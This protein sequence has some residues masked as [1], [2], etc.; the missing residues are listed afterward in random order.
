MVSEK[1]KTRQQEIMPG[2]NGEHIQVVTTGQPIQKTSDPPSSGVQT[3]HFGDTRGH[4]KG[5]MDSSQTGLEISVEH[6]TG[7]QEIMAGGHYGELTNGSPSAKKNLQVTTVSDKANAW[8][9]S[10]ETRDEQTV[11]AS[12][13]ASPKL[14]SVIA[15]VNAGQDATDGEK[16]KR[17]TGEGRQHKNVESTNSDNDPSSSVNSA[18]LSDCQK[19]TKVGT[20]DFSRHNATLDSA[21]QEHGDRDLKVFSFMSNTSE[22]TLNQML[23]QCGL[24]TD[25][26]VTQKKNR[27][28]DDWIDKDQ[29]DIE[30]QLF[31][32]ILEPAAGSDQ[33]LK[34]DST[35]PSFRV[36][37]RGKSTARGVLKHSVNPGD[38]PAQ[39]H[40][41]SS[42]QSNSVDKEE[43]A[44]D[45]LK[46]SGTSKTSSTSGSATFL[47]RDPRRIGQDRGASTKVCLSPPAAFMMHLRCS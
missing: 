8:P 40:P 28:Y 44:P 24:N 33:D 45:P 15:N 16:R 2:G 18:R 47:A 20:E 22:A 11:G 25:G 26:S 6:Q 7:Q 10:H 29:D 35:H 43:D 12:L 23:F 5:H 38:V 14:N 42:G 19:R 4:D 30:L 37:P 32:T 31:G 27:L 1:E 36:S 46:A 17:K 13:H 34:G 39:N 9:D 41:S 3:Q 21:T